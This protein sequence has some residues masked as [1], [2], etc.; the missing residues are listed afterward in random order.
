MTALNYEDE[1]VSWDV[2]TRLE[3]N[4]TFIVVSKP[5]AGKRGAMSRTPYIC[6]HTDVSLSLPDR[7]RNHTSII[8]PDIFCDFPF[9]VTGMFKKYV[10]ILSR[11]LIANIDRKGKISTE[12]RH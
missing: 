1:G 5:R 12:H 9:R 3:H 4:T 7:R 11:P 8:V 2:A 6:V 10:D